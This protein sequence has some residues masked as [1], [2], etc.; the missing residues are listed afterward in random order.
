[1]SQNA[2]FRVRVTETVLSASQLPES[3]VIG[4]TVITRPAER[5]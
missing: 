2:D 3:M 1:M 4:S 5:R